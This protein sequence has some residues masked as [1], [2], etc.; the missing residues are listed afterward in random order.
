MDPACCGCICEAENAEALP[1]NRKHT[2][3]QCIFIATSISLCITVDILQY[4]MP[5][6]FLPSVLEDRGHGTFEIATAIGVYYWTGF[7]GCTLITAYQIFLLLKGE[8]H[9]TMTS[10]VSARRWLVYLMIG[11]G[12][13]TV[14]LA[15]QAM[16]PRLMMHTSCRFVQGFAGSF[17]FFY[18]F[19]LNVEVF[20]GTQQ[21]FSMTMASIALNIAEVLGSSMGA[22]VFHHFGQRSVFS[23][24]AVASLLNQILLLVVTLSLTAAERSPDEHSYITTPRTPFQS[25]T[26]W[27]RLTLLLTS[28]RMGLAVILI[29]TSAVVK[30]SVE[31]ILPFHADHRWNFDPMMI[32][33]LFLIIALAYI[34]S[35]AL[36]GRAWVAMHD[37]RIVFSAFWLTALGISAYCVLVVAAY[38]F[39]EDQKLMILYIALTF[40]GVCLGLTHTPSA[41]L[42]ADA[43]EHEEGKAKDAVNGIWNTMWE[44]GGSLGF[45]LGG[46]LAHNYQH[47]QELMVANAFCCLGTAICML[48][49]HHFPRHG[50]S[51]PK[52]IE[53]QRETSVTYGDTEFIGG[54][55]S[56]TYGSTEFGVTCG[57]GGKDKDSAD[58]SRH[59]PS[60]L[61]EPVPGG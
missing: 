27:R 10:L 9:E 5:L 52:Q 16:S 32:G 15:F 41:L 3:P 56:V 60:M 1:V 29:T 4:S 39:P 59:R 38:E 54:K 58:D 26:S 25:Q 19:L 24:L 50:R 49:I 20:E 46:L 12:F 44:A 61:T 37:C 47:Q 7:L 8:G 53:I 30:G 43:I 22:W 21:I 13:G 2:W 34:V 45:L 14:T 51:A 40:Y 11:L 28:R 55:D 57:H 48:I 35:A 23:F 42:L 33:Q 36:V 31:E 18:S 17:I 6:A